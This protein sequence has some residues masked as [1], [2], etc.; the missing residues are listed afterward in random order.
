VKPCAELYGAELKARA[1]WLGRGEGLMITAKKAKSEVLNS[2]ALKLSKTI[3]C[4][5]GSS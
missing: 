5:I 4:S 2:L 1:G 3:D